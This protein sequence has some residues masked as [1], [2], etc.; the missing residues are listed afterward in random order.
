VAKLLG[1]GYPGGPII[2]E[3]SKTGNPR[4]SDSPGPFSRKIPWTSVFSGVKTAVVNYIKT[5]SEPARGYPKDFIREIVSAFR[6]RWW[7]CW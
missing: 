4:R 2:D 5:H 1:L 7:K 3:L 6:R